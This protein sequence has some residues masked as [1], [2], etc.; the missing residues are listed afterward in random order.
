MSD[1]AATMQAPAIPVP[2]V[3]IRPLLRNTYLWMAVGLTL[4]AIVAWFCANNDTMLDLWSTPWI[5]CSAF[6]AQLILV[7]VLS[8]RIKSLAPTT[9]GLLFL[10]Y[11]A[12]TG[13]SLTGIVLYFDLGTLSVAFFTTAALFGVMTIVGAFT[14]ADL[15]KM[16]TYL[17]IGLIGL[18]IATL[19]NLFVG[20]DTFDFI[21]S[22]IGVVIFTGLTASDTQKI[23]R[24]AS[25]PSL[26]GEDSALL[27]RLSIISAL[28]LY[29]DFI[30]LFLFLLRIFGRNR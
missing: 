19:I 12:L 28:M 11:A 27:T 29:L 13:F 6:F 14:K 8:I 20:S 3:A 22:L 24:M 15:T 10:G 25:D 16:G 2:K 18:L 7:V 4:T 1:Y 23:V 5:A 26:Q 30:N 17:F 21:I 9:A